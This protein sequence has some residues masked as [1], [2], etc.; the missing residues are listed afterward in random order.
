M[1]TKKILFVKRSQYLLIK[2]L[3]PQIK[4]KL[5]IT[6]FFLLQVFYILKSNINLIFGFEIEQYILKTNMIILI[7]VRISKNT[8]DDNKRYLIFFLRF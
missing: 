6:L 8:R 1:F 7:A 2:Q 3:K 5:C 4:Q